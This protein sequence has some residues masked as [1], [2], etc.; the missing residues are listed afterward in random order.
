LR[1]K[2]TATNLHCWQHTGYQV[3]QIVVALR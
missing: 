2:K 3:H 1:T